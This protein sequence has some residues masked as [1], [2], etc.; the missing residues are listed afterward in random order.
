MHSFIPF[1]L[2]FSPHILNLEIFQ[3]STGTI[4]LNH[5]FV[6]CVVRKDLLFS[7]FPFFFFLLHGS[8]VTQGN[9]QKTSQDTCGSNFGCNRKHSKAQQ[10]KGN[11]SDWLK[12][13]DNKY[14]HSFLATFYWKRM[15]ANSKRAT[16][17]SH[18]QFW[19]L[20]RL[21]RQYSWLNLLKLSNAKLLATRDLC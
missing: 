16:P 12:G 2:L 21:R 18:R 14:E 4:T 9:G 11:L 13:T 3:G 17:L 7:L 8:H 20:P 6:W 5:S 19:S 1:S 10:F 15:I